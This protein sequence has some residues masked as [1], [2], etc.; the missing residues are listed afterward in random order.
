MIDHIVKWVEALESGKYAQ[1]TDQLYDGIGFCC[2]GVYADIH[3][4]PFENYGM[5]DDVP[6]GNGSTYSA[7]KGEIK[8]DVFDMGV[9]MNDRGES[10]TDI[11]D[12][13]REEYGL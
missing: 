2:L 8:H 12:M 4:I 13:I 7:I 10:F 9:D 11:A 6:S 3:G 1:C 5:D